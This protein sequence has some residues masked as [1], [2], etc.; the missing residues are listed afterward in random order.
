MAI[1]HTMIGQLARGDRE[2]RIQAAVTLVMWFAF[3]AFVTST[4]TDYLV[5]ALSYDAV[6]FAGGLVT[7]LVGAKLAA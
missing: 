7:A 6:S 1:V 2:Q 5:P 3:G 4:V